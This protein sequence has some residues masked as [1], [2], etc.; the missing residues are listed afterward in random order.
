MS[1]V[2]LTIDGTPS[3]GACRHHDIRCRAHERHSDPHAV[4]SAER[5]AGGRVP[6][7]RGGR[8][9]AR[10]RG[11]LRAARP[12]TAWWSPPTPTKCRARAAPWSNC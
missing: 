5:N 7:M 12:K 6:R 11:V 2:Q 10:L 3:H 8:G 9:R 1:D 4:P